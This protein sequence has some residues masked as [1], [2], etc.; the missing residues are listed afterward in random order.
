MAPN[1]LL[2][3][4]ISQVWATEEGFDDDQ[5][6]LTTELDSHANMCVIG[7]Q[8]TII[9][10]TG[11]HAEVRAF[12]QECRVL[13]KVPIVDAAFAYDC[14]STMKTYLLIVRNALYVPTMEHNLIPPFILREGGMIV[15]DVPRIH[16]HDMIDRDSHCILSSN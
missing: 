10:R 5:G 1:L 11:K 9:N 6:R 2:R 16:C 14:P 7:R 13:N 15:N 4:R 12:S 8:A 3:R